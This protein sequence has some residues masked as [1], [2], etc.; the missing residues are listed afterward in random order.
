MTISEQYA[1]STKVKVAD[2]RAEFQRIREI[3]D[4]IKQRGISTLKT[5]LIELD[6]KLAETDTML[7]GN[8][9]QWM[10][11]AIY[12]R[13]FF[14]SNGFLVTV[15]RDT[16]RKFLGSYQAS[17]QT[18]ELT[19][20]TLNLANIDSDFAFTRG[21]LD[22]RIFSTSVKGNMNTLFG[23][24]YR[25]TCRKGGTREQ[26]LIIES[27][28]LNVSDENIEILSSIVSELQAA[29]DQKNR[30]R[31]DSVDEDDGIITLSS[32]IPRKVSISRTSMWVDKLEEELRSISEEPDKPGLCVVS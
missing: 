18:T 26:N 24:G 15:D 27:N 22:D 12:V 23:Y 29:I 14:E 13:S 2:L 19:A 20:N 31:D 1:E 16:Y 9:E 32:N 28:Q 4:G 30:N 11:M 8:D 5:I 17:I 3:K 7:A 25:F 6:N 21:V 10:K